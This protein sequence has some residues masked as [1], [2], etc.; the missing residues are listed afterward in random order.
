MREFGILAGVASLPSRHGIGDFGKEAYHFL[1]KLHTT[2]CALWQ[3]LPM[4]PLGYGNSPYQPYSSYALEDLYIS[5]EMLQEVG[6]LQ[7][8]SNFNEDSD[9]VD[10][11]AVRHFKERY[12]LEA[13]K[14]FKRSPIK[15]GDISYEEFITMDWVRPF[16]LFMTFKKKHNNACWNEWDKEYRDCDPLSPSISLEPYQEEI[17]YVCFK[18]Y[19]LYTQWLSLK[20]YANVLDIEIIGDMPIY[21]GIDSLDVWSNK[22]AFLLDSNGRPT[23]IAGVPP[24][25]FSATGQRWGNPIYDWENME[26]DDFKFWC[27]RLAY[28]TQLYDRVRIDHFRAFDT[29]WKI[30]STCE[31]AVEGEWIEAP[32]Y[33][34]F[35]TLLEKIDGLHIIAE[36]L[37]DL[38]PE[39]LELRDHYG[40]PGMKVVHFTFDPTR[41]DTFDD[42]ENMIIYTGTHDNQM[43]QSWYDSLDEYHKNAIDEYFIENKYT[44]PSVVKNF[45]AFTMDSI[46]NTAILPIQDILELEDSARLNTPGTLGS[47][48]WEWKLVSLDVLDNALK[49]VREIAQKS[50]RIN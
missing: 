39:V 29:Y 19:V 45:L 22:F 28:S 35:D 12:L 18:Q 30:P 49:F 8:V 31:T 4:H 5:L 38:R 25:Y 37:G 47:P 14:N 21:V 41:E 24:D 50:Q 15:L 48:N 7:E 42:R 9:R 23:F 16:G 20:K 46:A 44:Y 11:E 3:V 26:K 43:T 32:G 33:K 17:D 1:D 40:F 36:D 6:L 13:Y 34:L 10:Y 2:G 27:D